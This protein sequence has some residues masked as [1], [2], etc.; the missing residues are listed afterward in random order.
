MYLTLETVENFLSDLFSFKTLRFLFK[1]MVTTIVRLQSKMNKK[2]VNP[3]MNA[4]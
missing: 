2:V 4:G 3:N 1:Q